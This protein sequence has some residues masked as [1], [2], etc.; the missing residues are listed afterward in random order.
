MKIKPEIIFEDEEVII[1]NKPPRFLTVPDRFAPEKENVYHFLNK[2]YGKVFIV[3][4]LDKETS[5]IILFAKNEKAHR[6]LSIQFE[7]RKVKKIYWTLLEGVLHIDEGT[8]DKAIEMH[9]NGHR[10]IISKNGKESITEYKVLERFKNFTLVQAHIKTGRMHQIRIHFE[11]IAYPLAIDS[12]YGRREAFYLSEVKKSKYQ[13][14]RKNEEKPLMDRVVLHAYE[15]TFEHP[16]SKEIMT[17]SA[18]LPKDFSAVLKQL[19]KWGK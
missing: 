10:M 8:I 18:E 9:R 15:L 17:F 14:N 11:S 7:K 19:K 2:K 5:G 12:V 4:R 16:T 13:S 1:V 6:N 3:H